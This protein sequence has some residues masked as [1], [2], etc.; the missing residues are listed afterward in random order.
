MTSSQQQQPT[1]VFERLEELQD[2]AA[3]SRDEWEELRAIKQ[4]LEILLASPSWA[5]LCEIYERQLVPR[6]A[7]LCQP[8]AGA[9][10]VAEHNQ[11]IGEIAGIQ[12]AAALPRLFVEQAE[13]QL[14]R[15]PVDDEAREEWRQ[16]IADRWGMTVED[17]NDG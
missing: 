4:E 11:T 10:E 5:R 17:V 3:L 2:K 1:E 14:K 16:R 12:L 6:R 9:A 15:P 7:S 13:E 8:L